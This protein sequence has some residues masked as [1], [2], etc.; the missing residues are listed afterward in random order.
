MDPIHENSVYTPKESQVLLKISSST[1]TRMIKSG[2]I[3][4]AKVGKQYRI[5]GKELLRILSPKL[6]D[7]VGKAYNRA[8]RWAHDEELPQF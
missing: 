2:L 8:R 6:E 7:G 5:M 3:R 1:M 4:A